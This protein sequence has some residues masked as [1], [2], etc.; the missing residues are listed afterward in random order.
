LPGEISAMGETKMVVGLG[1]PGRDY[2]ETRHNVGFK[3]IH[4]L[5][6]VL[7][8]E[9]RKKKFGAVFG[10][11]EF[12]NKKLILLKPWR[13]MNRSGR[14]VA[15]A[16]GFY[17]LRLEDVLVVVD[18]MDLALG[19]IRIR[20]KG[21]SGGHKGL[22][23]VLEAMG[24]ENICRL[25]IGIGRRERQDPVDFVLSRPTEE[26]KE[27]LNA[28]IAGARDAVLCW[29]EYGIDAAMNKFN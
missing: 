29:A 20:Q 23:D 11:G 25:R 9:V 21:S 12:V 10:A 16:I 6:E 19:R 13:F 27:L 17:R 28:A 8:I 24:S 22:A 26:E 4:A 14:P 1:N 18:D 5:A 2:V 15:T 3:V 7:N